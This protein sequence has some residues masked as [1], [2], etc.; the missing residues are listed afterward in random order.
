[1]SNY[2]YSQLR[3]VIVAIVLAAL[4]AACSSGITRA[5]E[6]SLQAP[7]FAET[8]QRAGALVVDLS[9]AGKTAAADNRTF[10]RQALA[11]AVRQA[12]VSRQKLTESPDAALP[13]I[14]ITVTSV[15]ARSNLSA[16][17]LGIFAGS[18]HI[19][20]D[21]VVRTADG[22]EQQRFSVSAEYAFGGLIGGLEAVRMNWLYDSFAKRVVEEL[23][24]R[25]T[26]S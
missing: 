23:T 16:I 14:E 22:R 12:L 10:D 25:S 15:R 5:P 20:G 4:V 19:R 6:V 8:D 18:D 13:R 11:N 9:D 26:S 24:G 7:Q 3:Q 17:M 2:R 21:V 1:M